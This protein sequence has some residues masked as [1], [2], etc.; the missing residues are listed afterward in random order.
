MQN[1]PCASLEKKMDGVSLHGLKSSYIY[2]P[3]QDLELCIIVHVSV[4]TQN[5]KI[6]T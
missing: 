1:K 5:L 6:L 4:D 3:L 2:V